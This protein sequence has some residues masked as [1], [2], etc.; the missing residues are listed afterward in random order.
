MRLTNGVKNEEWKL[1]GKIISYINQR[2]WK[3]F[4]FSNF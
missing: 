3:F 2:G 1:D 4:N